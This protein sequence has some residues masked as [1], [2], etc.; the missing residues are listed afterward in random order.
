M[1]EA[2]ALV[3]VTSPS[4]VLSRMNLTNP[5]ETRGAAETR[6]RSAWAKTKLGWERDEPQISDNVVSTRLCYGGQTQNLFTK[7][8][9]Y[10][11]RGM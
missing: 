11:L 10:S 8:Q 9:M 1:L 7:K 4:E 3:D 6:L 5:V 2:G